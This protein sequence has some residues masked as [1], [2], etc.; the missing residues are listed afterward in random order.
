[1]S[2]LAWLGLPRLF[3]RHVGVALLWTLLVVAAAV[4]ASL[5]TAAM[6]ACSW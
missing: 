1:M 6:A 5:C 2:R 3:N 4:A